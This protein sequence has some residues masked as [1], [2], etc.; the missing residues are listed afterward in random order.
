MSR[1]AAEGAGI[2]GIEG[3]GATDA[4]SSS[5][6][7]LSG[8]NKAD[9]AVKSVPYPHQVGGHGQLRLL[10]SGK[11]LKPLY[12][13][14]VHFYKFIHNPELPDHLRWLRETTPWFYGEMSSPPTVATTDSQCAMLSTAT[15][16]AVQWVGNSSA[17]LTPM[18]PWAVTMKKRAK[19]KKSSNRPGASIC[20][21]DVNTQFKMP[22]VLD[23]KIGTRQYDDDASV[24]KRRRHIAK[25][26]QTTSAKHGIRFTGM[27]SYKQHRALGAAYEFRDKYHGRKITGAELVSELGW[28]FH[29][30]RHTR[31]DCVRIV[32]DKVLK[33]REWVAQQRHF[34][35]YSSSLL[36]MYEGASL[37]QAPCKADVRMIDF[38]HTQWVKGEDDEI[39]DGYVFGIDTLI[40]ILQTLLK[41]FSDESATILESHGESAATS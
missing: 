31:V 33:I 2:L 24:E 27:Q 15:E 4:R 12:E 19:T 6:P 7:H 37:E 21:E 35:F 28:Y 40:E 23:L 13:K 16:R 11:L 18:S 3:A 9:A 41:P 30:G 38:A 17:P 25:S 22:C 20:L 8:L 26:Q 36:L 14:E 34:K 10:A 39:D 5:A 29:D 1:R 32:L